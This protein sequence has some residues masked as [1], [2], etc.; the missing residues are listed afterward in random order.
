M[1]LL[2]I[3]QHPPGLDNILSSAAFADVSYRELSSDPRLWRENIGSPDLILIGTGPDTALECLAFV[4]TSEPSI[5][6][7]LLLALQDEDVGILALENGAFDYLL[8]S[9]FDARTMARLIRNISSQAQLERR[10]REWSLTQS[11]EALDPQS[12]EAAMREKL[13]IA[14]E[15]ASLGTW[16]WNTAARRG[17]WSDRCKAMCG[18]PADAEMSFEQ[19][20]MAVH[21]ED[22]GFVSKSFENAINEHVDCDIEYRTLWPDGKTVR[23]LSLRGRTT[24]DALGNPLQTSGTVQD[25]TPRRHAEEA[26]RS[27][28]TELEARVETRTRELEAANSG[29]HNEMTARRRLEEEI[30]E[31]SEREQSRLGQDLHDGLGQELAGIALLCKVLANKLGEESHLQTQAAN[32]ICSL[33][34]ESIN[35]ARYL[36]KGFYPVELERGGLLIALQDLANHVSQRFGV[37]CELRHPNFNRQ[38]EK[39]VKI[40]LYRMIQESIS[41]AI[42][43]GQAS[44][45]VIEAK[46]EKNVPLFSVTDDGIGFQPPAPSDP[47]IGLHLMN[48]RARLIGAQITIENPEP[49]GCRVVYRL[50]PRI[51]S[52]GA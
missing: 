44:S 2:F 28:N 8:T 36:A 37:S 12:V 38:L 14:L 32:S 52:A 41:N 40:H 48:Y 6:V 30:L 50:Q 23:W 42:K 17:I 33:I 47:G 5:P 43:H 51:S 34:S 15:A 46:L 16:E 31:I 25:I 26:L 27:L 9:E 35:S 10:L 4:R 39:N 20:M 18:L 24:Y 29:L 7:V 45:I 22:Q 13:S 19:A 49:G 21:P 1:N 3:G 11:H